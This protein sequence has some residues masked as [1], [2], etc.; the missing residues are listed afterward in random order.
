MYD[1]NFHSQSLVYTVLL[2]CQLDDRKSIWPV[3]STWVHK[4]PRFTSVLIS[5]NSGKLGLVNETEYHD[6]LV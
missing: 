6:D 3:K 5:S 2:C 4:C 1:S